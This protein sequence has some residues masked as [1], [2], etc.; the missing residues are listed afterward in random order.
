M[1]SFSALF[2]ASSAARRA[3]RSPTLSSLGLVFSCLEVLVLAFFS[4]GGAAVSF[5]ASAS[6]EG[7]SPR[8]ISGPVPVKKRIP[9]RQ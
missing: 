4:G 8:K 3:F 5:S 6:R 1:L 2:S 9:Y 7:C